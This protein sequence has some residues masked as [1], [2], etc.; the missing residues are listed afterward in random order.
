MSLGKREKKRMAGAGI[1]SAS[2]CHVDEVAISIH[3]RLDGLSPPSHCDIPRVPKR[4]RQTN[5]A[6]YTPRVLAIGPYHLSNPSLKL[7]ENHKLLYVKKFLQ[8]NKNYRLEDY[9]QKVKSWEDVARNCYDKQTDLQ[10]NQFVEMILVDGIFMIELFL[11]YSG[12]VPRLHNDP[13][14]SQP[15]MCNDVLRDMAM[16]ENQ[17]PFFVVQELYYMAFGVHRVKLTKLV[18]QFFERATG[19]MELPEGVRESNVKHLVD[20]I[21]LSFLQQVEME[22]NEGNEETKFTPSATDL[23]AAGVKLR[24]GE[25]KCLLDIELKNGVLKIPELTLYDMTESIFRNIIAFEQCYLENDSYLTNYLVF[26]NYLVETPGDAKLLIDKGII[27]N[28][29]SNNE[30]VAD[31]LNALGKEVTLSNS[32]LNSLTHKLIKHCEKPR[33][34]WKATFKRDYCGSPW[35]LIS[36]IAAAVLLLLTAIQTVCTVLTLK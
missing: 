12:N 32:Y 26:M 4:L 22:P 8:R 2:Y 13:I 14:I 36:V 29:L 11:R 5:E 7:M 18:C 19:M 16:L 6:A 24:S 3:R 15:H 33:N 23:V 31:V 30:A 21:R 20:V 17:I 27:K 35:A 9:I 25:S 1:A 34:K 28:C 10:P